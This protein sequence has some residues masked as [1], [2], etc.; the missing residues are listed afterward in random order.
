MEQTLDQRTASLLREIRDLPPQTIAT[1]FLSPRG[2]SGRSFRGPLLFDYVS[3]AGLLGPGDEA[4]AH[5]LVITSHDGFAVVVA[6][7]EIEPQFQGKG[8]ILAYE[9][10]G[11][12]IQSGVRLV[13]PGDD[14]GG[15][16][17][18]GVVSID[19]RRVAGGERASRARSEALTV[20]GDVDRPQAFDLSQLGAFAETQVA[21]ETHFAHGREQV[22]RARY[23]GV[24]V[25]DLLSHAGIQTDPS[26]NEDILSRVVIARAADGYAVAVAAGEV[27]PRFMD[28]AVIVATERDGAPLGEEHGGFRLVAPKDRSPGRFVANLTSIEIVKT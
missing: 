28:H 19:V 11:E 12:P 3:A 1:Q 23:K 27:E 14:L 8:I 16:Y 25:F 13:V 17:V 20:V 24:R 26:I 18:G 10:D 7:A 22:E 5:Y 15:R 21:T 4:A 2:R 9:Q 6:G